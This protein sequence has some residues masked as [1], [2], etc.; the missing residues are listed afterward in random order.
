MKNEKEKAARIADLLTLCLLTAI[1][2][3]LTKERGQDWFNKFKNNEALKQRPITSEKH[4]KA[5]DLDFQALLKIIHFRKDERIIVLQHYWGKKKD[6]EVENNK[7]FEYTRI[8]LI[9]DYRN[10]IAAHVSASQI[11]DNL[12]GKQES[13]TYDYSDAIKDM[14]RVAKVFEKVVNEKGISYY[15]LMKKEAGR[16]VRLEIIIG[17]S[18]IAAA[19][20]IIM[21]AALHPWNNTDPSEVE[22]EIIDV[23]IDDIDM[24]MVSATEISKSFFNKIY[25]LIEQGKKE[26]FAACFTDAYSDYEIEMIYDNLS[27][28]SVEF[29][30]EIRPVAYTDREVYAYQHLFNENGSLDITNKWCLAYVDKEWKIAAG[31]QELQNSYDLFMTN[32]AGF[33]NIYGSGYCNTDDYS[34]VFLQPISGQVVLK[35]KCL[36]YSGDN[37]YA[38]LV[39]LNGTDN[40]IRDLTIRD[41]KVSSEEYNE[42]I[43]IDAIEYGAEVPEKGYGIVKLEINPSDARLSDEI[44]NKEIELKTQYIT[45]DYR[46]DYDN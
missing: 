22:T 2:T 37:L 43:S 9:N 46:L 26:Q 20:A 27:A 1:D 4:N 31:S 40:K 34:V 17:A 14:L 30:S 11:S 18:A 16:N 29:S 13:L 8:R 15:K 38:E 3:A 33:G 7:Y 44:I 5:E 19:V 25:T 6:E 23:D 35:L 36:E 39:V 45:I 21:L 28:S 10:N 42:F 32:D 24:N 12:T 41:L